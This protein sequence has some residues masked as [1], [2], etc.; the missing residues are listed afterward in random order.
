MTV[1]RDCYRSPLAPLCS[2]FAAIPCAIA[3]LSGVSAFADPA[4]TKTDWTG[5][6][7]AG[8]KV[9]W[10]SQSVTPTT[11]NG[12]PGFKEVTRSI[13]K[14]TLLGTT[15][16]EDESSISLTDS[17][18]QPVTQTMDVSS[19]GSSIHLVADYDYTAHKIVCHMGKGAEATV[20]TI[21]IPE[22]ANL[23]GSTDYVASGKKLTIGLTIDAYTL[24]PSTISLQKVHAV[25]TGREEVL[26][27]SGHKIPAF[28]T[29]ETMPLGDSTVWLD[30]EGNTLK[31]EMAV[32]PVKLVMT[33][34]S[35][36]HAQNSAFVSPAVKTPGA[37]AY[38]PPKDL[39][40]A[41]SVTT[42]KVIEDPRRTKHISA[43]L[44]GIPDKRLILSDE[45]QNAVIVG[46]DN[47]PFKV[48][49]N[50]TA[51]QFSESDS[52][53]LP[54]NRPDMAK[55]LEKAAYLNTDLPELR[56]VA[57][58]VRGSET[59]AYKVA[60]ALRDWVHQNMTPDASIGVPRS[61]AD[62]LKR[63]RGV[64][65]DYATLYAA[66]ARIAGIPTRL[67]AGVVYAELDGKPAF[68]YHAWA[69][70]FLGKWVA[71]DPTLYD[72]S[73]GIDYTD[74]THIKFAQGEVTE[75]YD[76]VSVIGKLK[77]E[78]K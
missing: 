66:L 21:A 52:L 39:A 17:K 20:R 67:C 75:M 55:Y 43:T 77:I 2:I 71:V 4:S 50:V 41:T 14:M 13:I 60:L 6:Y 30:S 61:A 46:G 48:E 33:A 10:A 3:L 78:L 19:N 37:P 38:T 44:S 40:V 22:G 35:R 31:A 68:Y 8:S 27:E 76:A 36:A 47:A 25:V 64:C 73:L 56:Q 63:K 59:N 5:I 26:D 69:E 34:E 16:E 42:E 23:A 7:M 72:R 62:V 58:S 12:K 53:T 74:A 51:E 15:V 45:R 9:G 28:V 1:G 18:H 49:L 32:G 65:R 70:C 24:D 29:H 54:I 11:V 57:L